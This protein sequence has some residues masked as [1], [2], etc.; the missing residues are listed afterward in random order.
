MLPVIIRA[1]PPG[2]EELTALAACGQDC[3]KERNGVHLLATVHLCLLLIDL[4]WRVI[5]LIKPLYICLRYPSLMYVPL[6]R[7]PFVFLT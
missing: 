2:T 5:V 7:P 1:L 3:R 6:Y 4:P